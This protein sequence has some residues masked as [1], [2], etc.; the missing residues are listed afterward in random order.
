[1]SG[2]Q[3]K[4]CIVTGSNPGIG[5]ETALAQRAPRLQN[6]NERKKSRTNQQ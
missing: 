6:A 3:G 4:V 5:K 1:M 2:I